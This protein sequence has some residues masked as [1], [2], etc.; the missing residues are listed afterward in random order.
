MPPRQ[1]GGA[2]GRVWVLLCRGREVPIDELYE[3]AYSHLPPVQTHRCKQQRVGALISGINAELDGR[4]IGP[5]DKRRTYR[6]RRIG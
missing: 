2:T 4:K 3:A 5:G 6:L 1:F